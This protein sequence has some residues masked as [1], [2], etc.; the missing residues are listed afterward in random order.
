V[1]RVRSGQASLKELV[2]GDACKGRL[3]LEERGT[4]DGIVQ[5]CGN[6]FCMK[7]DNVRHPFRMCPPVVTDLSWK[8]T[9]RAC[10]T[11]STSSGLVAGV[12][13]VD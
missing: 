13:G 5:P 12:D 7:Y 9:A 2:K 3:S 6:R 4:R 10:G 8:R 1:Q 11:G